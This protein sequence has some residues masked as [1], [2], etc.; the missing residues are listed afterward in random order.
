MTQQTEPSNPDESRRRFGRWMIVG[1]WVLILT[2]LTLLFS[3]WLHQ[4]SNPNRALNVISTPTEGVAVVLESNRSG[5]YLVPG[6]INGVKVT[7]LVDTGATK[8]AVP[9]RLADEAGL[10]RLVRGQSITASGMTESWLT[11]IDRLRLGPFEMRDVNAAIIP[12]MPGDEVLL[13]MS[14]L[15]HLKLEQAGERLRIS[16]PD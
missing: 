5:H 11:R 3:Q 2:V 4:R 1:T 14:F 8:V 15:K 10:Q 16:L 6:E 7:F 9:Q 12:D 13:G